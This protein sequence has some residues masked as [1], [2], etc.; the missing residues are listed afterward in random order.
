MSKEGKGKAK[1][2]CYL[3]FVYGGLLKQGYTHVFCLDTDGA[4]EVEEHFENFKKYYGDK[5]HGRYVGCTSGTAE[6]NLEKFFE[7]VGKYKMG[8]YLL[9][10]TTMTILLKV[11]KQVAGVDKGHWLGRD[12]KDDE[13]PTTK[14][15]VQVKPKTTVKTKKPVEEPEEEAEE[16]DNADGE[17]A[18][19]DEEKPVR[20]TSG[21]KASAKKP[22]AKTS[23][24]EVKPK[25]KKTV[26]AKKK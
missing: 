25:T 22:A 9:M 26:V 4:V 3:G 2:T 24:E 10:E 11:V 6:E 17:N 15:Q 7:K 21:K 20:K 1:V 23:D 5:L 12:D 14:P 16:D 18:E 19:E 8:D 13:E